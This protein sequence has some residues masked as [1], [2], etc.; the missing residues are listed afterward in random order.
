MNL[1]QNQLSSIIGIKDNIPDRLHLDCKACIA[2]GRK[3]Y[4]N[5]VADTGDYYEDGFGINC[6]FI[7]QDELF[8]NPKLK[9]KIEPEHW[10]EIN[11]YRSALLW[12]EKYLRDPNNGQ[13]WRAWYYQRGPL[14][15]RSPRKVYRF[16][17]RC[18]PKGTP[19]L[20]GDGSWRSIE[21]VRPGELVASKD[22]EFKLCSQKILN[23]WENG[24]K[25][26]FRITLSNGMWLECTSNHPLYTDKKEWVSIEDGLSIGNKVAGLK[27]WISL[28]DKKILDIK[29]TFLEYVE[30]QSI[31]KCQSQNTY[32][33]EVENTH[34]LVSSGILSHNTG[35]CIPYTSDIILRDGSIS[36]IGDLI[37]QEIDITSLDL[38]TYEYVKSTATVHDN[39]IKPCVKIKTRYGNE[40]ECTLNHPLLT[41]EGW[42]TVDTGLS[43]GNYI[44]APITNPNIGT[45]KFDKSLLNL[46]GFLLGDGSFC[47][48]NNSINFTVSCKRENLKD[49][50]LSLLDGTYKINSKCHSNTYDIRLHTNNTIVKLV[51]DLKLINKNSYNKFIPEFIYRLDAEHLI[52]FIWPLFTTDGWG[53]NRGNIGY[54]SA[55]KGLVIGI[56][57]ILSRLGIVSS[58]REKVLK[59]GKYKGN[60]YHVVDICNHSEVKK[61]IFKIGLRFK[62]YTFG[63]KTCRNSYNSQL[64]NISKSFSIKFDE[65][66]RKVTRHKD[67]KKQFGL[68]RK[69][70][71]TSRKKLSNW[72]TFFPDVF[73]HEKKILNSDLY[74]DEITSIENIGNVPTAGLSVPIYQNY[75]NDVI[76]HNTTILAVEILW[77]LF[78][79]AGGSVR[80]E[81]TG[82]IRKNLKVL[83]LTPQKSHVA[84][85]FNR[86]REFLAVCPSLSACIDR[87]K[88]GSPEIISLVTRDS[89]GGGN[90]VT[91]FASG[92]SSGSKGLSARGQDAD[93]IVL[94]EGAFISSAAIQ[95]VV[96]AIL[97]THPNTKFIISSTPSGIA[98]DYFEGICTK[99]PDFAEFYVPA[100]KRPDWELVEAQIKREFGSTQEQYDK[101]VL[102][103]FSPA[104]IG[105]Y[106]EDLVRFAKEDYS[107]GD[108]QYNS[109]F[110]YTFGVDWNKEHGTEIIIVGT[111]K[112]APHISYIVH[113]ENIPKKSHT[114][115]RGISR[116]IELNGIWHPSWIYVDAGGGD[117]GTMLRYHGRSMIKKNNFE[118]NLKDIVKDF[119][120]GSKIEI[121]E[122]DGSRKKVPAKPFMIENS[123]KK[124]EIGEIKFPRDDLNL[125]RQLNNYIIERRT[126]TGIPIY[127]SKEKRVGD[128]TLDS[129]NL[130]LVAIRLEF[131]SFQ[132]A[133][134]LPLANPIAF[135]SSK[136]E[137][138]KSR[139]ILPS[140]VGISGTSSRA[141]P[142][143]HYLTK[144]NNIRQ[145]W[146]K[147]PFESDDI[148]TVPKRRRLFGR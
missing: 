77:Y 120:F 31:I 36:K 18:L 13:P 40:V 106:R 148:K 138:V 99:R 82:K 92:D 102:A 63:I 55:S 73:E 71:A 130:S 114:S 33:I 88:R 27:D 87:N 70:R 119:D 29:N 67:R 41:L 1:E 38:S 42:K 94:D 43:V 89:I 61:F 122:H 56:K 15:C 96:L 128:H 146:G 100:T 85:I 25:E 110:V 8:V 28:K 116:I 46:L 133:D 59:S 37:G 26:I 11:C 127:G 10:D 20:M 60:V 144:H 19:I 62:G 5:F 112:T 64:R 124:F 97:Y 45:E 142:S 90:V 95:G 39:G 17:R 107:Y 47:L 51:R 23:F 145:G 91:G 34:N 143:K 126:P 14:L 74:W 49:Y 101:E 136:K 12:G 79:S 7:P 6:P 78:T 54:C 75:V 139:I 68:I 66:L 84:E 3:K 57:R 21:T 65:K 24:I 35:K 16:G 140:S 147:D 50:F 131:P 22:I 53:D 76:E 2:W 108:M 118:A 132:N 4:K 30:I 113:S 48:G 141:I 93:L 83:L 58:Y 98:N 9:S 72:A 125:V 121:T 103:A 123:V 44:A 115:P 117:G 135:V 129:L 111:K 104:G 86:I 81:I 32:D 109:A 69:N 134:I 137:E 52:E 80:D 105:V